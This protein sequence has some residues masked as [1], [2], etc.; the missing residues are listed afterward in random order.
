[1]IGA[2]ITSADNQSDPGVGQLETDGYTVIDLR[3][4]VDLSDFNIGADGTE[5]FVAWENITDEEVRYATSVLKEVAPA[6]GE[7]I[8]V[9]VRFTF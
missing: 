6:P 2:A 8:R 1:E 3:G 7:N 9:G 4:E 5:A